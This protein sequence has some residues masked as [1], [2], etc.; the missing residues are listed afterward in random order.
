M[1]ASDSSSPRRILS[2]E[3]IL[4]LDHLQ[5]VGRHAN[6][7][8]ATPYC[9]SND[10]LDVLNEWLDWLTTGL[11]PAEGVLTLIRGTLLGPTPSKTD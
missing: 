10:G 7:C 11:I 1:T 8:E 2:Q 9:L 4:R 6:A 5:P 3:S